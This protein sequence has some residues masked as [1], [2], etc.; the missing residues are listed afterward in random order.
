MRHDENLNQDWGF[1]NEK[2]FQTKD[3]HGEMDFIAYEMREVSER[4]LQSSDRRECPSGC[5]VPR[6]IQDNSG[7]E[8]ADDELGGGV[9]DNFVV[10]PDTKW[11]CLVSIRVV[12]NILC[13]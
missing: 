5:P 13:L 4:D 12:S 2:Q 9:I 3:I 6:G 10:A 11:I 1:V 7:F 8:E